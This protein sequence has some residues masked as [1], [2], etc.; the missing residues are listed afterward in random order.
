MAIQRRKCR[1]IKAELL[2]EY[3]LEGKPSRKSRIKTYTKNVGARGMCFS[4]EEDIALNALLSLR[5]H[6]DDKAPVIPAKARVVWKAK[7]T[8]LDRKIRYDVGVDVTEI[9]DDDEGRLRQY[10]FDLVDNGGP[11]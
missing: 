5:I 6:P 1:R 11:K 2:I 9:N 4:V 7:F 10:L 3:S 8:S